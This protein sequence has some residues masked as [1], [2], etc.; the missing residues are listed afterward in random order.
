M[1][2]AGRVR[3]RRSD[4]IETP[5]PRRLRTNEVHDVRVI[6]DDEDLCCR[7]RITRRHGSPHQTFKKSS[8][9]H[10]LAFG[11]N[12]DA[13]CLMVNACV[14]SH[15]AEIGARV[16]RRH[17]SALLRR[18]MA[19]ARCRGRRNRQ[20]IPADNHGRAPSPTATAD[21]SP[22]AT[23]AGHRPWDHEC[24]GAVHGATLTTYVPPNNEIRIFRN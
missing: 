4:R 6:F 14:T 18:K 11:G 1:G 20:R 7:H 22:T 17:D 12:L 23:A 13:N 16:T 15:A 8:T 19:H 2:V 3:C 9:R 21:R 24:R 5:A 10:D